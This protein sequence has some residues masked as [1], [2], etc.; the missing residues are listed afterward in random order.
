MGQLNCTVQHTRLDLA[1]RV[2]IASQTGKKSSGDMRRLLKM[3]R[4]AKENHLKGR[5]ERL[6]GEMEIKT[7]MNASFNNV[8]E[9]RSQVGFIVG[10][11]DEWERK[12]PIYWKS[13]KGQRMASL[14][15]EAEA[16][17]FNEGLEMAL[18]IKEM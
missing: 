5:M 18:Y 16:V 14:M 3:V 13:R 8:K 9:G 4:R 7:Y 1:F 10:I 11:I 12:C 2:S 6:R 17:S 15:M